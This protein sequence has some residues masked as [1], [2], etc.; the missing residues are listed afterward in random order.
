QDL[1]QCRQRVLD[2]LDFGEI[3]PMLSEGYA[4]GVG[5]RG[6]FV[7]S[8]SDDRGN[9]YETT[10]PVQGELQL[11]AIE[12]EVMV[13]EHGAGWGDPPAALRYHE[14]RLPSDAQD[15]TVDL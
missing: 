14:V 8:W 15:H 6:E 3:E 11:A 2:T 5:Y 10:E 13:A 7:Y 1:P 12:T 4:I 9:S